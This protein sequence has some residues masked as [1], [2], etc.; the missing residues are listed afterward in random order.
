MCIR[1]RA[2]AD[3]TLVGW[4]K[5][6]GNSDDSSGYGN[7]GTVQSSPAYVEGK[8]GQA[9]SFDGTDDYVFT[10]LSY[11][12]PLY[13]LAM[14]FR[15]DGGTGNRAI[16]SSYEAGSGRGI[17]IEIRNNDILRYTHR[18]P[19]G[20]SGGT[21]IETDTTY[22]DGAW[23]HV[24]GVKTADEMVLYVNGEQVVS[25]ADN[26]QFGQTPLRVALGVH[27]HDSLQRFFWGPIDDVRIYNRALTQGEIQ[28][29]MKGTPAGLASNPNPADGATDVLRDVVLNWTPGEYAPAVNGQKVYFSENFNDVNEGIGGLIQ[30]DNSYTPA[31][32]LDFGQTYYWRVDEANSVSGW[33]QGNVWQFTIEPFSF[34]I[35]DVNATASSSNSAGEGPENTIN[36][37]GLDAVELHSTN[38]KAMWLSS[39][40]DPNAAWIQYEFDRI[41]KLHQVLVW[42]Y[43]TSV[44]PVI[45]FGIK[46]ATIEYSVDGAS[47]TKLGTH[48]FARGSGT[49]GYAANTTVDLGG[50]AAKYV[51]ITANSNWGGFVPQYGLSE[52]RFFYVPVLARELDPA[53]GST[54]MDVDNVTL[55]WKAG[56]E[57][58]SH[59]VHLSDS[60]Q[61]VIDG[62]ALVAT[63][64]EASYDTGEL[65]LNQ[66]YY[67]KIVEVNEAETPTS[68]EGDVLNFMTREFLVVDD[69]EDYNNFSPDRVFQRWIDGIGYSADEFFPVENPGNGT[70]AAIGHDIWS[71]DSP[72]YDGDI[73]ETTIVHGG[74]QSAPLY[75]DNTIAPFTSEIVRTFDVPQD[76]TKH[77]IKALTLYFYG[78]PNNVAQQMYV[79]LNGTK[80]I[81]DGDATNITRIPWQAWNIDLADL[82]GV[83]LSNLTELTIGLERIGFVGGSG[84]VYF[85]DISLYP[86]SRELITPAE[87]DTASLVAHYEFE[88]TANDSSGNGRNGTAVGDPIFVA[89]KVGQAIS[90]DGIGD[91]VEIIG[92]K[93]ILGPNA[94][95]VTAWIKTTATETG[96]IIGWG[97]GAASQRF[98]FRID[99]GRL[100]TEHHGGNIQGDT[101][102]NDGGWHHVAVTVQENATISYP[103]V[104]LYLNG[105]DDTRPSTDP[106]AYN[107]TADFDVSIGRR[108]ASDD[109][110]FMGLIDDVRVY[111][112]V[113]SPEEISWLAGRTQPFD[114]PF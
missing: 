21:R 62:T 7:H 104:V 111:D 12:L 73:M 46:E 74:A 32:R 3:P 112:R 79:K 68:W 53:S 51:K 13:S 4:Y 94:I 41:Y 92:Y 56:R 100:R 25:A 14:W 47:W 33:D 9:I 28:Q 91:Y 85:D 38:S 78:D 20:S 10:D 66:N 42:N 44:E 43:N 75:Y 98:G 95:T 61:A 105:I 39:V 87:P 18:F 108:P 37:S 27:R 31:Q 19:F 114:K 110:Y 24:A 82:V 64:S 48:E 50:V 34:P 113:L 40:V 6:D 30:D 71:Y 49:A 23:Y 109:R 101:T 8:I 55:N 76:W 103:E 107:I 99:D 89:G 81:Y 58:A 63:V 93:G 45:G 69:F 60:N 102:M 54:D 106:D 84:V 96:A 83:N 80:V 57:A 52:V 35:E 16:F 88:G 36:G 70:G 22:T 1:D 67:W 17:L 72:H 11:Q 65:Q 15:V 2:Y 97:S 5:F 59:E 77:G 29:A 86:Y 90:L 26:T